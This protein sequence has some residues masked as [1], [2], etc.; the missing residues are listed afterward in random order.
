MTPFPRM[1]LTAESFTQKD[2]R[3][4]CKSWYTVRKKSCWLATHAGLH[5][6]FTLSAESRSLFVHRTR[7]LK[8][9]ECISRIKSQWQLMR[10]FLIPNQM[11]CGPHVAQVQDFQFKNFSQSSLRPIIRRWVWHVCVKQPFMSIMSG[12]SRVNQ[13]NT[14]QFCYHSSWRKKGSL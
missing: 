3:S 6:F 10:L 8:D 5:A 9:P 14:L 2:I 13:L 4:T 7:G 12:S 1:L 11:F